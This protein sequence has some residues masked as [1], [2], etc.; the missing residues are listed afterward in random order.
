MARKPTRKTAPKKKTGAIPRVKKPAP[1]HVK[2][3]ADRAEARAK[4]K[5]IPEP[6]DV[7]ISPESKAKIDPPVERAAD[8]ASPRMGRP[9]KYSD[10]V[11]EEIC[12]W[13]ANGGSMT[14]YCRQ[15]GK[16]NPSTIYRWLLTHADFCKMYERARG[17]QADTHAD[18]IVYIAD[19]EEDSNRAR[20]RI[21]AR[22]WV[23]AKLKPR[24]YGDLTKV[25]HT[26]ADGGPVDVKV[27][28]LEMARRVAYMLGRATAKT[29][30]RETT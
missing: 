23:A 17:D 18:E 30:T 3:A 9:S 5:P 15:P 6:K 13:L 1:P 28:D 8:T 22:K 2:A 11:A 16:P 7:P 14:G 27:S 10:E 20:V 21:D 12:D 26:G 24:K 4:G 19:T 29:P 25:E